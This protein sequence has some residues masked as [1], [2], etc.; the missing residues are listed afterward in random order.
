MVNLIK[1]NN[2]TVVSLDYLIEKGLDI[3]EPELIIRHYEDAIISS[4]HGTIMTDFADR[5]GDDYRYNEVEEYVV[6]SYTD[7]WW[8]D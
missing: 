3:Y 1:E 8:N 4:M 2:I 6:D 7:D 5:R